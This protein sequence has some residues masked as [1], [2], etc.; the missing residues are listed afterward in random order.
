MILEDRH[1]RDRS[2]RAARES[3]LVTVRES[4]P[5]EISRRE[6]DMKKSARNQQ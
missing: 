2:G 1:S 5:G 4:D 3:G 6:K